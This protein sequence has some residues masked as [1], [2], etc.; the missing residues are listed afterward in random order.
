MEAAFTEMSRD[1]KNSG[2]SDAYIT[3]YDL[4]QQ[5]YIPRLTHSGMYYSQQ[6]MCCNLSI[7]DCLTENGY[8]C[9]WT[10]HFK[11]RGSQELTSCIPN[12]ANLHRKKKLFYWLDNCGGQNKNQFMLAM[13]VILIAITFF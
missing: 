1:Q 10:E 2:D 7:H 4:Q 11:G 12:Y 13:Y 5:I 3:T 6:V 8:M 9:I